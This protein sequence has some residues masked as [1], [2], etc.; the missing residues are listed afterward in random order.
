MNQLDRAIPFDAARDLARANQW[1]EKCLIYVTRQHDEILVLEHTEEFPSAGVQ[2]P[3]GGVDPG[4]APH[5][6]ALRELAEETGLTNIGRAHHLES[7]LWIADE[8]PS[9]VRHYYWVSAP[10][11]TPDRWS[12]EVGGSDGDRGMVFWLSF[13][14]RDRHGLTAGYGWESALDA[15]E[16]ALPG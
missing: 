7:R 5:S 8:A 9:R 16:D 12:H 2:V 10:T 6:T 13:R 3:A 1:R 4:E 11:G 15:L 14:R